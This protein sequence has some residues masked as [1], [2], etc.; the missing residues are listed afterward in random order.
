MFNT[1]IRNFIACMQSA[2]GFEEKLNLIEQKIGD[3]DSSSFNTRLMKNESMLL[4]SFREKL[5]T[6]SPGLSELLIAVSINCAE[7][8]DHPGKIKI[9]NDLARGKHVINTVFA[10]QILQ[11]LACNIPISTF[12]FKS[13]H[14][15]FYSWPTN[16]SKMMHFFKTKLLATCYIWEF[17]STRFMA[18]TVQKGFGR[19]VLD[20][21][22]NTWSESD[23]S[24]FL[25]EFEKSITRRFK[26]RHEIYELDPKKSPMAYHFLPGASIIRV[27]SAD[28]G[29]RKIF[30]D[31][32][33]LPFDQDFMDGCITDIKKVIREIDKNAR[34]NLEIIY[35][36]AG[37][38]SKLNNAWFK[39]FSAAFL[40][41]FNH[42]PYIDWYC[43]PGLPALFHR[44]DLEPPFVFFGPG[45]YF[46][47]GTRKEKIT[48]EDFGLMN[49]FLEKFL[50]KTVGG[51]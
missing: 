15:L 16:V 25:A 41:V 36:L 31:F 48:A 42:E 17:S 33:H 28:L 20:L 44:A 38:K 43:G 23:F 34:F 45:E 35:H 14:V 5:G 40:G 10:G 50:L 51:V 32:S 27:S 8:H 49:E 30:L 37:A 2:S 24:G 12:R 9:N 47:V 4:Y 22:K 26:P 11:F 13:I 1:E 7:S 46:H 19:L 3:I 29:C 21:G 6:S 39:S 18:C